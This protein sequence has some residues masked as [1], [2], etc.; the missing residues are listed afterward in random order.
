M[1]TKAGFWREPRDLV[2]GSSLVKENMSI[3]C[4]DFLNE[5][6]LLFYS[7]SDIVSTGVVA[8]LISRSL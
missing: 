6:K 2:N 4:N 8:I 1:E 3:S 5:F 7:K